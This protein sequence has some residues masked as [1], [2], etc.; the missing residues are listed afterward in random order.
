MSNL[1]TDGYYVGKNSELFS[2]LTVFQNYCTKINNLTEDKNNFKYRF[3]YKYPVPYSMYIGLDEIKEREKFVKDNNIN[4]FQRWWQYSG[5]DLTHIKNYFRENVVNFLTA[6]YGDMGELTHMDD[7]TL[8]ENGDF[9]DQHKDGYNEGRICVVLIYLSD[10]KTYQDG[11]GKLVI[12]NKDFI[13]EVYPINEN[14]TILDFTQNNVTHVVTPVK[15][16]FKRLTYIN[17]ISKK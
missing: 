13:E 10:S 8:F 11:G 3:D 7:I 16:D 17:F 9:I 12:K 6:I 5:T 4:T 1:I 15:N 14:F 2:D